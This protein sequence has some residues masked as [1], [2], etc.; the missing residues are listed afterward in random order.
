MTRLFTVTEAAAE[1]D[2]STGRVR[3]L[4]LAMGL[5]TRY[6]ER[7]RLLTAADIRRLNA[8]KKVPGP[9]AKKTA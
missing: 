3:A 4:C 5:G 7:L 9:K 2:I 8:R 6:G 1:L